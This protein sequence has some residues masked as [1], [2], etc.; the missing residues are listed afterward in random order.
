M[1]LVKVLLH[2]YLHIKTGME[3]FASLITVSRTFVS[4]TPKVL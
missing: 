3:E 1:L 4:H 2:E